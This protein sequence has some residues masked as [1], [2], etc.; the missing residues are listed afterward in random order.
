MSSPAHNMR[1][2]LGRARGLGS[3]KE[4]MHHWWVQRLT[5]LAL[6]P[7]T[8][9]FVASVISLAGADYNDFVAW[10]ANPVNA[11]IM[12]VFLAVAFHHA[13]LGVQVVL[14]DYVSS[15]GLRVASIIIVKLACYGLAALA[16]VSTLIVSFGA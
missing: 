3:A 6:I 2:P 16:I 14:E 4:G 1:S 13:Q 15:H 10:L 12:V 8:L 9:W 5:S 7:L 11:T